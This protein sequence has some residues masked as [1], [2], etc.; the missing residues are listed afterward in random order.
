MS[1][2]WESV[3]RCPVCGAGVSD[4]QSSLVCLGKKMH[5][6]DFASAGYVNLAPSK[7]SG[8]GDD[9]ELIR[10]R[11]AFLD[12]EYY[13]PIADAVCAIL[14]KYCPF[15]TVVDAGCG[16]GYYSMKM[17]ENGSKIIGID[18]SKRGILHAA[19]RAKRSGLP[20]L[21]AVAGIFDIP[22]ADCCADA[23]VSL[24]APVAE[25]EFKRILK[26]NGVLIIAGAG[27]AHLYS[28][29]RVLYETPYLNEARADLP[30]GM[31]CLE[32]QRLSYAPTVDGQSLQHLFAMTPYYY[33]T[34]K[35][36]VA[37]L[38]A[39]KQLDVDVEL[40]ISVYRNN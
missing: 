35:E 32:Q 33:R 4:R 12:A 30:T 34:P 18:L 17:A 1:A 6:F 11:T 8:A 38:A 7:A 29:K 20:A 24:F 36:G 37:R 39:T 21:F 40:E 10:A 26:P 19:K 13:R 5:C 25:A 28:L 16:E 23:V 3:L 2:W 27:P 14:E 31:Q 22:V 15:G 9:A